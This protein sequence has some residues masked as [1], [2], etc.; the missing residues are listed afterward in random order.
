MEASAAL[1][2]AGTTSWWCPATV[3]VVEVQSGL[4]DLGFSLDG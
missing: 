2:V 4:E 1:I 3:N